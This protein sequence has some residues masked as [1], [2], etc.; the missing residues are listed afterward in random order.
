MAAESEPRA[1]CRHPAHG[2]EA[3]VQAEAS[4]RAAWY[5][6]DGSKC[7][8]LVDPLVTCLLS[9]DFTGPEL[10]PVLSSTLWMANTKQ[11]GGAACLE[12]CE[13]RDI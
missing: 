5:A 10:P 1:W 9:A 13:L 4:P 12:L 6:T 3:C 2:Q 7:P 11:V 8:L